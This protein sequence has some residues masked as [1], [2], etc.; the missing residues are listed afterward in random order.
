MLARV[1]LGRQCCSKLA[2]VI[3]VSAFQKNFDLKFQSGLIRYVA[4][5]ILL[6]IMF[7]WS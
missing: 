3:P 4:E 2:V 6:R 7:G 1:I 5:G